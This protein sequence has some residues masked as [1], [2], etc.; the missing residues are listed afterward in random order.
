M[1]C[2]PQQRDRVVGTLMTEE[3]YM[4]RLVTLVQILE[5]MC[6]TKKLILTRG[7]L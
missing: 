3:S 1:S 5:M 2:R 4:A 7:G 6:R